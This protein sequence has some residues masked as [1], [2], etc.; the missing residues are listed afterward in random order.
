[1][2]AER[3]P[4]LAELPLEEKRLLLNELCEDIAST[5]QDSPDPRIVKLLEERWQAH[6]N[7]P[8]GALTLEEFRRRPGVTGVL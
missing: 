3:F 7:D 5:D 4:G 6:E 2:I 8:S 1:M